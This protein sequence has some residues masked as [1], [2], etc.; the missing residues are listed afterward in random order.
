MTSPSSMVSSASGGAKP[1]GGVCGAP[2]E[3]QLRTMPSE[4]GLSRGYLLL[5]TASSSKASWGVLS[6][7]ALPFFSARSAAFAASSMDA[8]AFEVALLGAIAG[9]CFVAQTVGAKCWNLPSRT[10]R[11][12]GKR[13]KGFVMLTRGVKAIMFFSLCFGT[14][15]GYL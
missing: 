15:R 9:Y 6:A 14:V 13:G 3:L 4:V 1:S 7:R 12:N 5:L 8:V 2:S 10:G 11:S